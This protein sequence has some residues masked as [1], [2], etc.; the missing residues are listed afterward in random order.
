M[1]FPNTGDQAPAK[2]MDFKEFERAFNTFRKDDNRIE[3]QAAKGTLSPA[4]IERGIRSGLGAQVDEKQGSGQYSADEL[5]AFRK[6]MQKAQKEFEGRGA[7]GVPVKQLI[8]KTTPQDV[9]RANQQIRYARL[10]QTRGDMLKFQVPASGENGYN[11]SYQVRIRLDGWDAMMVSGKPWKTAAKEAATGRVSIDCQCGRHQFWYRYLAG[12]GG[13]AVTPPQEKDFPKIRNPSLKGACCKHVVRVLQTLQSPTVQNVLAGEMERQADAAGYG[14]VG[15]RYLTQAEH[16]KLKRARPRQADQKSAA[17]AYRDYLKSAKGMKQAT[18]KA[19]KK[20]DAE[21]ENRTLRA[22]DRVRQQQ[23]KKA[24][25]QTAALKQEANM[26]KLSAQLNKARMDAV[27]KAA[28][29]G[30]DPQAAS[31]RATQAFAESWAGSNNT[32][33]EAV[34]GMIKDNGL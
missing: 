13:Y 1:R 12:V 29:S 17:A 11:G 16:E 6:M 28:T 7:K 19:R 31:T 2:V 30:S 34:M 8:A 9:K 27:M 10:Y 5:K 21:E 3:R 32:T 20:M 15:S 26:A 22:K 14:K 24:K 23:L 4:A 33:P 25:E 18:E